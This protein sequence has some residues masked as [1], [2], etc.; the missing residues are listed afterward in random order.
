MKKGLCILI[1]EDNEFDLLVAKTS[2]QSNIPI[3]EILISKQGLDALS[4]LEQYS[5]ANYKLPSVILI[6]LKLPAMDG[7]ELIEEIKL[8]RYFNKE[9]VNLIAISATLDD[10]KEIKK[11]SEKGITNLMVKPFDIT[12][13]KTLIH[14]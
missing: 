13:F 10:D 1:V 5:K 4:K 7:Y 3:A 6:D 12:Q 2:I 11:A 8:H 14:I 9:S